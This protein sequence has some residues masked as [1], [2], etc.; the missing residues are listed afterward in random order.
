MCNRVFL[1]TTTNTTGST[2]ATLRTA[3]DGNGW[4]VVEPWE[5]PPEADVVGSWKRA[6]VYGFTT[7][8]DPTTED[9]SELWVYYNARDGWEHAREAIGVSRIEF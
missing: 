6:Y 4:D 8:E 5:I 9:P 1:D 2:I 7:L 3:A